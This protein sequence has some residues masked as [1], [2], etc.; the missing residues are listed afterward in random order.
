MTALLAAAVPGRETRG[1]RWSAKLSNL[2]KEPTEQTTD[3]VSWQ[4]AGQLPAE[5]NKTTSGSMNGPS[6][7]RAPA[8]MP[9]PRCTW[10]GLAHAGSGSGSRAGSGG[11][12]VLQQRES[13]MNHAQKRAI[14]VSRLGARR[15]SFQTPAI[16]AR[17]C[18]LIRVLLL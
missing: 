18:G 9:H 8:G 2:Q 1:G 7:L 4:P 12:S 15:A 11:L 16:T 3:A 10:T 13:G 17:S 5:G 6:S 14:L